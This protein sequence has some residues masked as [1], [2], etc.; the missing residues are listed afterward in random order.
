M[1][2]ETPAAGRKRTTLLVMLAIVIGGIALSVIA[3]VART[4]PAV[5]EFLV[6]YPGVITPSPDAPTGIP[7]WLNVTHFLN[8]LFLMLIIRTALSIRSKKRPPA[9][10]T[11]RRHPLGQPPRRIGINVWLHNTVDLLWMLNGVIYVVLLFTTGQWMR[12]VPT[13]WDVVPNAVS[14]AIQ[15][16]TFTW[17]VENPWV[18][19]NSLQ[20]LSYFGVVFVLAPLAILTGVR[21]SSAWPLDAPRLNRVLPEKPIRALHNIVLF[22]FMA[23]IVVHV[24]LVLFTGAVL[25]LNVMFAARDDLSLVGTVIFIAALAVLAGVWFALTDSV[26]KRLARLTGEVT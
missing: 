4:Q 14:A 17:P 15:Y 24:S 22:V 1:S 23:F 19:Y 18:A 20:T 7:V 2:T 21:L 25:N 10:V 12:I 6:R 8:I 3:F 9:F 5:Q 13:T 11:P 26:Q 16:L